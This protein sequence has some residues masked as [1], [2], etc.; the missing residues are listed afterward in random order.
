MIYAK[1]IIALL[2]LSIPIG[3]FAQEYSYQKS[4]HQ[5]GVLASEGWVQNSVKEKYWKY[6]YPSGVLK[7]EGH[8]KSGK[9]ED[10]WYYYN[11]NGD[12]IRQGHYNAGKKTGWWIVYKNN[13]MVKKCQYQDDMLNGYSIQYRNKKPVL[14]RKFKNDSLVGEWDSM[15]S[16]KKENSL[17]DLR[18]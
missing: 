13:L 15:E 3:I 14:C 12:K 11:E 8:Y 2:F 5:E 1:K 4:Y 9:K 6:Y 18:E 10:F 16:F 17:K 7:Q